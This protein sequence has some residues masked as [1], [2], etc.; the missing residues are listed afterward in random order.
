MTRELPI[1]SLALSLACTLCAA[2]A[3][4]GLQQTGVDLGAAV[5]LSAENVPIDVVFRVAEG[6][7]GIKIQVDPE[8]V[9]TWRFEGDDQ[10][11]RISAVFA[12]LEVKYVVAWLAHLGDAKAAIRDG[13]VRIVPGNNKDQGDP[14][15][16][17]FKEANGSWR[18]ALVRD[19]N[20]KGNQ[21]S[22][23]LDDVEVSDIL[24]MFTRISGENMLLGPELLMDSAIMSTRWTGTYEDTAFTNVLDSV[25][26]KAK[27]AWRLEGGVIFITTNGMTEAKQ[28]RDTGHSAR[29]SLKGAI[30]GDV[31]FLKDAPL[32]DLVLAGTKITDVSP[33]KGMRL[34]RLDLSNTA[35]TDLSPL[36]GMTIDALYL[37]DTAVTNLSTLKGM[38]IDTLDLS[39]TPLQDLKQVQDIVI[40]ELRLNSTKVSDLTPLTG[41]QLKSL[42]LDDTKVTD[43]NPLWGMP[44]VSLSLSGASVT[45]LRPIEGIPLNRLDISRTFV[46][47]LRPLKGKDIYSVSFTPGRIKYGIEFLRKMKHLKNINNLDPADFWP[48]YVA[49][50]FRE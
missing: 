38:T 26:K 36:K 1:L 9:Q 20:R 31:S 12:K 8:L 27:F 15:F 23:W 50:E 2:G 18:D 10:Q 39:R 22:I 40:R 11:F 34:V 48:R 5:T 32:T 16:D 4:P 49:G 33:L 17:C 46:T 45:D 19:I 13:V 25:A 3:E 29:L 7:T 24:R 43:L 44:L 41:M 35:V 47:D 37:S 42:D 14:V 28:S 6:L 21:V 30:I